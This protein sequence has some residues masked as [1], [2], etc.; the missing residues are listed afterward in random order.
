MVGP[1]RSKSFPSL[2]SAAKKKRG[3]ED[4]RFRSIAKKIPKGIKAP[5]SK[6]SHKVSKQEG[7]F[8]A[9][10]TSAIAKRKALISQAEGVKSQKSAF[11]SARAHMMQQSAAVKRA[12]AAEKAK[13]QGEENARKELLQQR[14]KRIKVY[15]QL[16]SKKDLSGL[17]AK[18]LS[19]KKKNK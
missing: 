10:R 12:L 14:R 8:I 11:A 5:S 4:S 18:Y 2:P 6:G 19:K 1:V 7:S 15:K 17:R 16:A 9:A 3:G 13:K